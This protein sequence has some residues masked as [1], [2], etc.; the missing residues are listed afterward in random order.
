[1]S[2]RD[3]LP[4]HPAAEL[5]PL[6]SPEELRELGE[7]IKANGLRLPIAITSDGQLLDGRNRLDAMEA[8]GVEFKF[9]RTTNGGPI[10]IDIG[11]DD[12]SFPEIVKTDPYAYVISANLHRRH[13]TAEQRQHLLI[14][15]IAR[16]PEKSDRQIGGEI[17][18]DHKTIASARAKGETTGEISPVEKRVGKD[19]KARRRPAQKPPKAKRAKGAEPSPQM[20][21]PEPPRDDIGPDS[22]SEAGRLRA[23]NEELEREARRLEIENKSLRRDVEDLRRENAGLRESL[24]Q[25]SGKFIKLSGDFLELRDRIGRP[26][27]PAALPTDDGLDIPSF[28]DRTTQGAAS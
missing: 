20:G 10:H 7:D 18:V 15:L 13:L 1:M 12:L 23:R 5:F 4:I 27:S 17:G 21:P 26:A 2:W 25:A 24:E 22:A 3:V 16:A 19:G 8:V 11:T 14:A 6:M 9:G 28:L